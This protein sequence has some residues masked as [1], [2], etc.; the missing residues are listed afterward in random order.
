[1]YKGEII[2]GIGVFATTVV[3]ATIFLQGNLPSLFPGNTSTTENFQHGATLAQ[4]RRGPQGVA[5]CS[6]VLTATNPSSRINLRPSSSTSGSPIGYGLVGDRITI[7]DASNAPDGYVWYKVRFENPSNAEGWIRGDFV[8]ATGNCLTAQVR[9]ESLF[10]NNDR[11]DNPSRLDS[12]IASEEGG[13]GANRLFELFRFEEP[14]IRYFLEVAMGS[15]YGGSSASVRRWEEDICIQLNFPEAENISRQAE[16]DVRETVEDVVEDINDS[17]TDLQDEL[18]SIVDDLDDDDL[19]QQ[20][21]VWEPIEVAIAG[22]RNGC[23][24]PNLEFY[25]VQAENFQTYNPNARRGQVGHVWTWWNQNRINRAKILV[26]SNY[27]TED[28]RDHVIREEIT[29]SLG[30][31]KD[32]WEHDDSIFYQGWTSTTEFADVDIAVIQMLYHPAIRVGMSSRD[33]EI[34]LSQF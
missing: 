18:T 17:L 28:Q 2:V 3:S 19:T 11:S 25:Y 20:F 27:L 26:A 29:Q 16:N 33:V 1:M 31:L 32:S 15:E 34:G 21:E 22:T 24:H 12:R 13:T 6:A 30:I 5:G 7:L 10:V 9:D 8:R 4:S 23:S 14:E